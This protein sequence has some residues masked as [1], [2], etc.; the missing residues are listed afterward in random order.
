MF[1]VTNHEAWLAG[2]GSVKLTVQEI[3]PLVYRLG[4]PCVQ[5]RTSTVA[6]FRETWWKT[7]VVVRSDGQVSYDLVKRF[8][9][10]PELSSVSPDTVVI[11]PNIP[12]F[13]GAARMAGQDMLTIWGFQVRYDQGYIFPDYC[14]SL[15]WRCLRVKCL[16]KE[17]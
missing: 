3:G 4:W 1:N 8:E 6:M 15:P 10:V 11:I 5:A 7:H 2:N 16:F 17:Q 13:S 14:F 12:F 9:L